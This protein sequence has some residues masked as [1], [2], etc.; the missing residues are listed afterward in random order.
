MANQTEI[1]QSSKGKIY[2]QRYLYPEASESVIMVNG[3]MST[4]ASFAATVRHL[5]HK[6]NMILFDLPFIGRSA[7]H[8][9]GLHLVTKQDE[10]K[11]LQ[12]LIEHYQPD[13]LLSVSW[14]GL[15]SLMTLATRPK[16]IKK[17]VI[18]A[19]STCLNGPMFNYVVKAK[20]LMQNKQLKD[21]SELLNQE[22]GKYLPR[23]I[24]RVNYRHLCQLNDQT[25][26]QVIF[27]IEQLMKLNHQDYVSLF[28]KIDI[29]ILFINGN[30]DEYTTTEDIRQMADYLNDCQFIS[31]R[32]A[33]H[34]LD[35]EGKH[36]SSQ[37]KEA[38]LSFFECEKML[39]H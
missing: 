22:I 5:E 38:L 1:F 27:H 23:A 6:M 28:E 17:A 20:V 25:Y 36:A 7:E 37:V 39:C 15:A 35:L 16:S 33:G 34:F 24:K 3:A 9:P 14:G 4:T 30:R 26:S 29:P 11:I 13:N 21:S 18:S 2:V 12:E 19:F 10:V 31:I 8:N 32:N